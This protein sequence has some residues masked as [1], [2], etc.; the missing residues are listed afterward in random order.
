MNDSEWNRI[1]KFIHICL[2]V[3][4]INLFGLIGRL[5]GLAVWLENDTTMRRTFISI[6]LIEVTDDVT[7]ENFTQKKNNK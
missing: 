1:N 7:N 4:Y 3:S 5:V 6:V 2:C